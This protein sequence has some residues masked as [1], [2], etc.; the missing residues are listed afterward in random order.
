MKLFDTFR[1]FLVTCL[2]IAPFFNTP[3]LFAQDPLIDEAVAEVEA[4]QQQELRK[5]VGSLS[6]FCKDQKCGLINTRTKKVVLKPKYDWIS[7]YYEQK[8]GYEYIQSGCAEKDP[9]AYSWFT[10]GV[11]NYQGGIAF[12]DGK[13]W[14]DVDAIQEKNEEILVAQQVST[15]LQTKKTE[16]CKPIQQQVYIPS[17]KGGAIVAKKGRFGFV[18]RRGRLEIYPN[19]PD[20]KDLLAELA[21]YPKGYHKYQSITKISNQL[22]TYQDST[23]KY[24]FIHANGK[25]L[26]APIYDEISQHQGFIKTAQRLPEEGMKYGCLHQEG[27]FNI[28][29]K[30]QS[31]EKM[32]DKN[33]L[34]VT[35]KR[36]STTKY[37]LID[38]ITTQFIVEPIF[39]DWGK[40]IALKGKEYDSY[41][42]MYTTNKYGKQIFLPY[43]LLKNGETH[44]IINYKGRPLLSKYTV[45]AHKGNGF[46]E[47]AKGDKKGIYD[48]EKRKMRLTAQYDAIEV[49][50]GRPNPYFLVQNGEKWTI[51]NQEGEKIHRKKFHNFERQGN[52]KL[53]LSKKRKKYIFDAQTGTISVFKERSF[54]MR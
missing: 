19:Y 40:N 2:C 30:Y 26:S 4:E 52:D 9:Q 20:L 17:V 8:G 51:I 34:L 21:A 43:L 3:S 35:E 54:M 10:V 46:I 18:N 50:E 38:Y 6:I 23:N 5:F 7:D 48:F 47:F 42:L 32:E 29:P 11:N 37:G 53:M 12:M 36:D 14:N 15:A 45:V 33:V 31:I 27:L 25:V 1:S 16:P 49:I 28:P 39:D 22:F 13:L 41:E 44:T 24:G